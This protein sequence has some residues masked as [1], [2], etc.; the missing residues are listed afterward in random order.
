MRN[1]LLLHQKF[2]SQNVSKIQSQDVSKIRKPI[3]KSKYARYSEGNHHTFSGVV[4]MEMKMMCWS[5]LLSLFLLLT[6]IRRSSADYT[7][8]VVPKRLNSPYWEI[9][10]IGCETRAARLTKE[11]DETVTCL[12][13]GPAEG[14]PETEANQ[15]LI[16]EELLHSG[17]IDG[18]ALAVV[19]APSATNIINEF[20]NEG[21]PT[22]TFDS[23]AEES[24]RL[25]YI[26]T[27]NEAM[28]KELGRVLLQV[29]ESGGKY[30]I[31]GAGSPKI[32]LRTNGVRMALNGTGWTEVSM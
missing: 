21:I 12:F 29:K 28:G 26:G 16:L 9:V 20:M 2:E 10:K 31:I 18:L 15:L 5:L 7:F 23:D 14:G 30:G 11:L 27:D 4:L 24:N 13:T 22:V 32:E 3:R 17:E 6:P 1:L 19:E 8:A 25:A